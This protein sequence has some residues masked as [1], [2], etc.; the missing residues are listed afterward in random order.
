[1]IVVVRHPVKIKCVRYGWILFTCAQC[2]IGC[3]GFS[4]IFIKGVVGRRLW[5]KKNL[6]SHNSRKLSAVSRY[7]IIVGFT[8]SVASFL[9][10]SVINVERFSRSR[11][12]ISLRIQNVHFF[13]VAF[14]N[15]I[16]FDGYYWGIL[17]YNI[18]LIISNGLV[19]VWLEK[20]S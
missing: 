14:A 4:R 18:S 16:A 13:L 19:K 11:V 17:R 2:R 12:F 10:L 1:M 6:S 9:W 7:R 3:T 15:S 8:H 20:A 5:I